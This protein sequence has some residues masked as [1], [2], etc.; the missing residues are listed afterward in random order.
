MTRWKTKTEIVVN[1][2]KNTIECDF[3]TIFIPVY[4]LKNYIDMPTYNHTELFANVFPTTSKLN[5]LDNQ[6]PPISPQVPYRMSSMKFKV[7]RVRKILLTLETH[8]VTGV[9]QIPPYF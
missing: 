3:L 4:V 6:K 5:Q 2:V 1:M 7:K 9:D 8:K